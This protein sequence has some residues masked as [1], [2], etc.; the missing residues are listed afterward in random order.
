MTQ[1][2]EG[3]KW[4]LKLGRPAAGFRL[5]RLRTQAALFDAIDEI[6]RSH[7]RT[8]SRWLGSLLWPGEVAIIAVI[9]LLNLPNGGERSHY[10]VWNQRS[11]RE[12]RV[13]YAQG[14]AFRTPNGVAQDALG[15]IPIQQELVSPLELLG[16]NLEPRARS[17]LRC[18]PKFFQL[19]F[20]VNFCWYPRLH[21]AL[22]Q[23][24][25]CGAA[26]KSCNRN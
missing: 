2:P 10:Q 8:E 13:L 26:S 9:L 17:V 1:I 5:G 25:G 20:V 15:S 6:V 12:L 16:G 7:I 22:P 3:G 23:R 21:Q 24:L 14:P 19:Q 11:S 18:E 4:Y